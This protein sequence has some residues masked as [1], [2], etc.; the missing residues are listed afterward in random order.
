MTID[1]GRLAAIDAAITALDGA[2]L[3]VDPVRRDALAG[4]VLI[5]DAAGGAGLLGEDIGMIEREIDHLLSSGSFVSSGPYTFRG[6]TL[7]A[8]QA[9]VA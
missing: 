4:A 1:P 3:L 5:A 6:Y 2:S 9:A 7:A 8:V